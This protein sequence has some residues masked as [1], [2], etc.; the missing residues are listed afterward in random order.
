MAFPRDEIDNIYTYIIYIVHFFLKCAS[1]Y[2]SLHVPQHLKARHCS[3]MAPS[4]LRQFQ[5]LRSDVM[6]E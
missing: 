4:E 3:Q 2:C 5:L 6:D 1:R